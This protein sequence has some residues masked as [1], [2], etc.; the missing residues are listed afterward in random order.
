[1][2]EDQINFDQ[3]IDDYSAEIFAYLWRMMGDEAD[4]EDCLQEAF[5]RAYRAYPRL[6]TGSNHRAWLYKIATNVAYTQL[7][8]RSRLD[9]QTIP[10]EGELPAND[11]SAHARLEHNERIAQVAAL[12]EALPS[13]QKAALMMRKYQELPY[14][15]IAKVLECSPEA[16]RANVYQALK[17]LRDSVLELDI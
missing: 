7:R 10:L 3:L 8:Q 17:R 12:V 13:K 9:K 5:L 11:P 2:P 15:Q 6:R 16:A 14:T 4:A 1:M